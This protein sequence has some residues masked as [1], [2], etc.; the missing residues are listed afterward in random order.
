MFCL[1]VNQCQVTEEDVVP[2]RSVEGRLVQ[3]LL[4]LG[5]CFTSLNSV[6]QEWDDDS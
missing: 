6:K 5:V 3:V 2:V 4:C 1:E